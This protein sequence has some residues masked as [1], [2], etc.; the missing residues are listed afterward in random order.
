MICDTLT[1]AHWYEK[2]HPRFPQAFDYLRQFDA[3]PGKVAPGRHELQGAE[4]YALVQTYDTQPADKLRFENH[5][6]YIDLQYV[7]TGHEI[8]YHLQ[9]DQLTPLPDEP[10]NPQRD[11][12]FFAPTHTTQPVQLRQPIHLTPGG[13][14]I[15][16]PHDA[17]MPMACVDKPSPVYKVV[18]KIRV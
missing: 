6:N 12:Q 13:W 17:H 14:T 5:R 9:A 11:L 18:V 7:V 2:L 10:Y 8:I 16:F 4:L 1:H 3:T 15:L